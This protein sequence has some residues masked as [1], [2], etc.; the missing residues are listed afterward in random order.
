MQCFFSKRIYKNNLNT[1]TALAITELT[2][3]YNSCIHSA[4]AFMV[5]EARRGKASVSLYD[6]IKD[7]YPDLDIYVRNSAI[8][9]AKAALSSIKELNKLYIDNTKEKLKKVENKYNKSL[10]YYN[11]L[12]ELHSKIFN[13][14]KDIKFKGVAF[15]EDG[16]V[17]VNQYRKG[18]LYFDNIYLFEKQYLNPLLAKQRAK[19]GNLKARINTLTNKLQKVSNSFMVPSNFPS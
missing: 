18:K 12:K 3:L 11:S 5:K 19:V 13:R 14:E 4:F 2:S 7:K 8:N 10:S 9:E 1:D 15:N 16:T 6:Y 17:V